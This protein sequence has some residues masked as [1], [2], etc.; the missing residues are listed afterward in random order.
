M[1]TFIVEANLNGVIEFSEVEAKTATD[2]AA[3]VEG[4]KYSVRMVA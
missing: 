1:H 3:E 4:L 2:A